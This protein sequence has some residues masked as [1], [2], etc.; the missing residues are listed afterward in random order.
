[1][2]T[3][4]N[5][6]TRSK[7]S[8]SNIVRHSIPEQVVIVMYKQLFDQHSSKHF[9]VGKPFRTKKDSVDLSRLSRTRSQ[10]QHGDQ[11][12]SPFPATLFDHGHKTINRAN[13]AMPYSTTEQKTLRTC[14]ETTTTA[15]TLS[16]GRVGWGRGNVLDTSN[17]HTST[18]KSAE[19]GLSTRA[20][21]LG[22]VTTSSSDLDVES[23]NAKFCMC[24][25]MQEEYHKHLLNSPLQRAA[26]S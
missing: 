6:A 24:Q 13:H 11:A 9:I 22:A 14:S 7:S 2:E 20:G 16:P 19:S 21:G 26:T 3:Q 5:W 18:G 1:M 8:T 25:S 17:A 23:S 4:G 15:T 12:D 10:V